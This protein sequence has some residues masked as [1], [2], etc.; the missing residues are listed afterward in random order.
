MATWRWPGLYVSVGRGVHWGS[1]AMGSLPLGRDSPLLKICQQKV[2]SNHGATEGGID[3][4][5]PPVPL[6]NRQSQCHSSS[7]TGG[8][9]FL[10]Q[11]LLLGR[12]PRRVK[13]LSTAL[14][15]LVAVGHFMS[16][17]TL[18]LDFKQA[19]PQFRPS[20]GT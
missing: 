3:S 1:P 2:A 9:L 10:V 8:Q 18:T 14:P 6:G 20:V 15:Q 16:F 5:R 19:D 7:F 17:V 12:F 11:T 4:C 13:Y